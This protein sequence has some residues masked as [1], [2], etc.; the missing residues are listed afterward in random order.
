MDDILPQTQLV[1]TGSTLPVVRLDDGESRLIHR[2]GASDVEKL[3]DTIEA[4]SFAQ[5]DDANT[6]DAILELCGVVRDLVKEVRKLRKSVDRT[7][8]KQVGYH[9]WN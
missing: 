1:A 8:Q 4:A 3:R 7:T 2:P 6:A 5:I 9:K